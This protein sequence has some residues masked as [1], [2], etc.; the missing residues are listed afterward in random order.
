MQI[1]PQDKWDVVVKNFR[2]L[3]GRGEDYTTQLRA[4]EK[5]AREKPDEPAL[6]FLLGYHYGFLGYPAEAV[7]QLEKCV[8]LAPQDEVARKTLRLFEDKLPKKNE[9]PGPAQPPANSDPDGVVP[10]PPLPPLKGEPTKD[11]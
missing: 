10:P 7:K 8:N 4:L 2:D 11:G 5:S 6:R 1:L 3:Y 9:P